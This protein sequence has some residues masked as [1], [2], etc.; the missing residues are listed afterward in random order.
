MDNKFRL[1]DEFLDKLNDEELYLLINIVPNERLLEPIK[2]HPKEFK[3]ETKGCRIDVKSKML[4]DRLPN[5]Y[6]NRMKKHDINMI[7][8]VNTNVNFAISVVNRHIFEVTADKNFLE[9]TMSS[10]DINDFAKLI[11]ILLD[12]LKPEYIKL[13]FK[14][15]GKELSDDQN[16]YV[17]TQT[18]TIIIKKELEDEISRKVEE[19]YKNK[20]TVI[21]NEYKTEISN[22]NQRIKEIKEKLDA[23]NTELSNEKKHANLLCSQMKRMEIEKNNELDTLKNQIKKL[24]FKINRMEEER[25]VLKSDIQNKNLDIEKL[26]REL[27][28]KYDE[29]SIAAQEKWS[30]DNS[31]LLDIQESLHEECESLEKTKMILNNSIKELETEKVQLEDKILE[32]KNIVS[33]FIKNID[34]KLIEKALYDSLLEFNTDG[35]IQA[36]NTRGEVT[37]LYIKDNEVATNIEECQNIHDFVENIAINLEN[38]G[39]KDAADEISY[40]IVGILAAGMT[41]LICGYKAREIAKAISA[42]YSGETPYI[43]TLPSGYTNSK[44]LLE[45]YNLTESNVVLIEDAV[46]TMNENALLPLLRERSEEGFLSKILLL[47]T[48]NVDSVKYMPSNLFNQVALVMISKYGMDRKN[49]YENSDA[50]KVLEEFALLND[51]GYEDKTIRKLVYDLKLGSSYEMLRTIIVGYSSELSNSKIAV[52]GYLKSELMF[53]CKCNNMLTDLE[54]NIQ[55]HQIGDD[56]IEIVRGGLD[57]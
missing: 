3:D 9:K 49:E 15:I 1:S 16:N 6:F 25:F 52:Q 8:I 53:I 18:K 30:L 42:S 26:N 48:E 44:E 40:Y 11:D 35:F 14:L 56:L 39:V 55:N 36:R 29:Y 32:Y 43:I 33:G 13:F 10:D 27:S 20:I 37:D 7:N 46:G 21:E 45:I 17:D 41:P 38:M 12:E 4:M 51:S 50:R 19:E 34:E 2:K 24:D 31:E 47:S 22:R 57:G 28:M 54:N 23:T 5:I